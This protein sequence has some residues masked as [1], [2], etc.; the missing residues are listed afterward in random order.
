MLAQMAIFSKS[1]SWH[2]SWSRNMEQRTT[3]F[4]NIE[5]TT[6]A[7][8]E[9]WTRP[10]THSMNHPATMPTSPLESTNLTLRSH[11]W[12]CSWVLHFFSMG[13]I[14]LRISFARL[15][16][17]KHITAINNY[18]GWNASGLLAG[19]EKRLKS[20]NGGWRKVPSSVASGRRHKSIAWTTFIACFFLRVSTGMAGWGLV[21]H[22]DCLWQEPSWAEALFGVYPKEIKEIHWNLKCV[23]RQPIT[24]ITVCAD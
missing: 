8:S 13:R 4:T 7:S 17:Y 3:T 5:P 11:R 24:S 14:L 21:V 1:C 23:T 16:Y 2:R 19:E 18:T 12:S 6:M 15:V 22:W 9:K 20:L 10:T